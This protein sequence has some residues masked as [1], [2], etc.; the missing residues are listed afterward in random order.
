MSIDSLD[1][2]GMKLRYPKQKDNT[3]SQGKFFWVNTRKIVEQTEKFI[4]QLEKFKTS[5]GNSK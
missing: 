1:D 5:Y 3:D 2:N 4:K